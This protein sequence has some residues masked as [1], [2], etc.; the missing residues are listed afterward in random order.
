MAWDACVCQRGQGRLLLLKWA[1]VQER[2]ITLGFNDV[3][4][5]DEGHMWPIT[6][7]LK[8]LTDRGKGKD[9][10]AREKSGALK[11]EL[12]TGHRI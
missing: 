2:Y 4:N 6:F 12:A 8:E 5:I 9:R 7:A 10:R 3:A 1:E 11:T